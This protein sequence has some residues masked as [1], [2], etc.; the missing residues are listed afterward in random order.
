[1]SSSFVSRALLQTTEHNKLKHMAKRALNHRNF[2]EQKPTQKRREKWGT[3][4]D[5][6]VLEAWLNQA[7]GDELKAQEVKKKKNDCNSLLKF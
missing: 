6:S 4:L 3:E 1:V 5:E 7:S 2:L